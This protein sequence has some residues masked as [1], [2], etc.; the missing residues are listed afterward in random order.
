MPHDWYEEKTKGLALYDKDGN[1]YVGIRLTK[2][3]LKGND[4]NSGLH[5]QYS[6]IINHHRVK[7]YKYK[8][9]TGWWRFQYNNR[10]YKIAS[11]G[12]KLLGSKE[13]SPLPVEVKV[14]FHFDAVKIDWNVVKQRK[15]VYDASEGYDGG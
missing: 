13:S 9:K 11:E 10:W 6:K 2:K 15:A 14:L 12:S 4:V 7:F 5:K 3:E 1:L 8:T